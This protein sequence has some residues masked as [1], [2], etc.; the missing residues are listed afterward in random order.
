LECFFIQDKNGLEKQD[1]LP[2]YAG[3]N[4]GVDEW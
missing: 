1:F 4:F 2:K 3:L